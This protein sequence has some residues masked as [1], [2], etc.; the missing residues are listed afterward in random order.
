MSR[1]KKKIDNLGLILLFVALFIYF[2]FSS[3]HFAS[4]TNIMS[5][6]AQMVELGFLTLGMAVSMLS[7]GMDL[8]IGALASLGTVLLAVFIGQMGWPMLP[9]ILLVFL[10][11]LLAGLLNGFLVAYLKVQSMLATLGTQ[12]LF[13]GI[14]LVI[15]KGVTVRVPDESMRIFGRHLVFGV[16]PFQILLFTPVVIAIGIYIS[17]S[18]SGRQIYLVGCNEEAARFTGINVKSTLLKVY[19]LSAAMAFFAALVFSSRISS[20]R[21][22]VLNSKV[23]ET[24]TAAVFGGVSTLGGVGTIGGAVLGVA[25][26]TIVRNGLDMMNVSQFL[27]QVIVGSLLLITLALRNLKGKTSPLVALRNKVCRRIQ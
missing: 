3:K 12:S 9:A 25:I 27:Q 7:G 20:G 16:I 8:S 4:L 24:V 14:G 19:L 23:L 15:S 6:F 13:T 26:I 22:D 1:I 5:L 21:A 2:A 18:I 11:M 10:L 17:R